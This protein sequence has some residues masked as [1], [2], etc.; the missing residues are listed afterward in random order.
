MNTYVQQV[1]QLPEG[2][3]KYI[4]IYIYICISECVYI[5]IYIYKYIHTYIH[6]YIH[7]YICFTVRLCYACSLSLYVVLQLLE[8]WW[9]N[10]ATY[11]AM[12]VHLKQAAT[13]YGPSAKTPVR[14]DPR[15]E[16]GD[17]AVCGESYE[18]LLGQP[19]HTISC[20]LIQHYFI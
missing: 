7:I 11:L 16:A 8:G 12:C 14:P 18:S 20:K 3:Y 2:L 19:F 1:L 17:S 6:T 13:N 15:L 4:Y 5:Y 9:Q 10:M